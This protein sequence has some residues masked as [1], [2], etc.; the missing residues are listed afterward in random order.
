VLHDDYLP[1]RWDSYLPI[2][3]HLRI[4]AYFHWIVIRFML[5]ITN[6]TIITPVNTI[7]EGNVIIEG[8]RI[9]GVGPS[10]TVPAPHGVEVI[11]ARRLLV[12]PGFIDLQINGA[13]G[14]D[15]TQN[16]ERIWEAA[17]G[18]VRF[19][20]T[21]FLPTIVSTPLKGIAKAQS[22]LEQVSEDQTLGARPLGLHL[23]GPF[24]NPSNK[25]A[26]NSKYIRQPM[27]VDVSDWSPETGIRLVTLA[28]ELSGAIE[29]IEILAANGVVVSGGHSSSDYE[30]ARSGI[31]AGIRY[32][33]HVFN[34]MPAIHQREPGLAG[35]VLSDERVTVGLLADGIHVHPALVKIIWQFLWD[36]RLNLV[37]DAMAALGKEPGTYRLGDLT[38]TVTGETCRLSDGT[39]A[40]SILS[41][42]K[43]LRNLIAFTG[44][45]LAEAIR[46]V[47]STPATVL[48]LADRKGQIAPGYDADLVLLT[49]D[50]HI[51]ATIVGGEVLYQAF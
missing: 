10:A 7:A 16:P 40:G 15:F 20:V 12:V 34:G 14:Y 1:S 48:G 21:S 24:I 4:I 41:L 43:A 32:A 33:T 30:E 22:V 39:L 37:T 25:G 38:V 31:D 8:G 6:A 35:A 17:R 13:F 46:T 23:E 26:H 44:C 19:G 11:D 3:S 51:A 29:L 5:I 36:G 27:A 45:S 2:D 18:L 42:D 49:A 9:A 50:H 28:P 47:S